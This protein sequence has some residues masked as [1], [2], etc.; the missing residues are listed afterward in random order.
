M[1]TFLRAIEPLTVDAQVARLISD[2]SDL[3][4]LTTNRRLD[5]RTA[6]ARGLAEYLASGTI[7]WYAGRQMRF[8]KVLEVWAEPQAPAVWPSLAVVAGSPADYQADHFAP[9]TFPVP[10]QPGHYIRV[11]AG[12]VQQFELTIWTTDPEERCALVAMVEDMLEPN[13]WMTGLRL[14]LPY[15]FG[16]RATYEKMS[17]Q[18]LD[19]PDESQR[20]WRRAV[21]AV[22]GA[23]PQLRHAGLLPTMLARVVT[24]VRDA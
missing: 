24:T 23:I 21:I 8:K 12:L 20:R 18:F 5:P 22:T 2:P 15:Y 7:D 19:D 13:E 17:V 14:E 3:E 1:Q 10:G 9:G 6:L 4:I 16:A 11:V